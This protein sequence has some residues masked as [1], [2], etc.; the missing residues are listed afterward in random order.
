VHGDV[1]F[2]FQLAI[3]LGPA[4]SDEGG[5]GELVLLDERPGRKKRITQCAT[6]V[7]DGVV[8]CTRDR[9]VP[10]GGLY[11]LQAVMHGVTTVT[12]GERFA[13]GIPF[14]DYLGG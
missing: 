8:F 2:P 11:G 5:G 10:I 1:F 14:H 3:T 13:V 12:K 6:S 7:G 9:L 4:S